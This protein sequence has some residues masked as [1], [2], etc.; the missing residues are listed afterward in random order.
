MK[1]QVIIQAILSMLF[2]MTVIIGLHAQSKSK[3]SLKFPGIDRIEEV[4]DMN[5]VP[6]FLAGRSLYEIGLMDGSFPAQGN[7]TEER[8]VWSHPIKLLNGFTFSLSEKDQYTWLLTNAK[9]FESEFYNARFL[10]SQYHLSVM[11]EDLVAENDKA[12]F[13][14]LTIK[15]DLP[16]D[17]MLKLEFSG[18]VDIRPSW[19]TETLRDGKDTIYYKN[20]QICAADSSGILIMGSAIHPSAN[21]VRQDTAA[22]I[23][24]ISLPAGGSMEIPFLI[25]GE[26]STVSKSAES[27]QDRYNRLISCYATE[28][29]KK[30]NEYIHSINEGVRFDCSQKDITDAFYCA[31]ANILMNIKDE[32]PFYPDSFLGAGVPVYPRLFGTD[33]CFSIAGCLSGGFKDIAKRTL[34]NLLY[35][36][37]KNLRGP[38]EVSSDGIL[39][40]WDHI[41]VSPQ[42]VNAVWEYYSWTQDSSFLAK[43][44]PLCKQMMQDIIKDLNEKKG[45]YIPGHGLMEEA[46]FKNSWVELTTAA[47]TFPA[48]HCLSKMATV[49]Q[50]GIESEKYSTLASAYQKRFNTDWWDDS[51]AIWA[52][53]LSANGEKIHS[54]F[55]NVVFPQKTKLAQGRHGQEA[56]KS[57]RKYWVNDLWGMVGKYNKGADISHDGVGVVHNNICATAA[58]QYGQTDLGWKLIQLSAQAPLSLKD[59][60]LGLFPECQPHG[61]SNISQLW[62]YATFIESI[63]KGLVGIQIENPESPVE[64]YLQIPD[65]LD[66]L[67]IEGVKIANDL[68]SLNWRKT[69]DKRLLVRI[70]CDTENKKKEVIVRIK[71]SLPYAVSLNGTK[72]KRWKKEL[73]NGVD[74]RTCELRLP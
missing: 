53:A 63:V 72:K 21:N 1:K 4:S 54:Y 64:M 38:H 70:D 9:E 61:C 29:E 39:L 60:P 41:Q 62:S 51:H 36:T 55:W 66:Y 22:L 49:M 40:G 56:F 34:N 8:G 35:Y 23:Y 5:Q 32:R 19:R 27:L 14:R 74:T 20:G 31:K 25:T 18:K 42:L 16:T 73:F 11:R 44:Y 15:N 47:Y 48:L 13:I 57:I 24:N 37:E 46:E 2:T 6:F 30:R 33:F 50:D 17:R 10:F 26:Y 3:Q 45:L 71:S 67:S 58:F 68:F 69:T 59:S 65:D 12:L 7:E 43:A 52:S 28:K